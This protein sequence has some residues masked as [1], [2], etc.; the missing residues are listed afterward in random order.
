MRSD[1]GA[2]RR[3]WKEIKQQMENLDLTE[4]RR[5]PAVTRHQEWSEILKPI[6]FS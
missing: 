4:D 3:R 2:R 5:L 6:R 1:S